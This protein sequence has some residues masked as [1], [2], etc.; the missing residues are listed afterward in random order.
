MV[1]LVPDPLPSLKD[2]RV[3]IASGR[4]DPIATPEQTQA[5]ADLLHRAGAEVSLHWT[6]AG[7]GLTREDLEA[8]E[9]WMSSVSAGVR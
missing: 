4:Q 7:H 9:R 3:L 1:P 8:G 5:L 2:V 6:R